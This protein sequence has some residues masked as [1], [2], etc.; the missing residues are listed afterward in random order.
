MSGRNTIDEVTPE[1]ALGLQAA[2]GVLL[3]VREG[4]EWAAGHAPEAVHVPLAQVG[5]A[6]SRF[7]GQQ[8]LAVCRSGGRSG[9]AAE[10]L[11][12]AGIDVRN[13]AGGMTAWAEAG[14]PV[15]RD[16]GSPGAVA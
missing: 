8:V 13:V 3:D 11:A 7:D 9:K 2:G 5:D 1:G 6:A 14:L 16:D 10:A 12:A 15:V 4:D